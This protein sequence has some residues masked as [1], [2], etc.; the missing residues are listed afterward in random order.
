MAR[1]GTNI[2]TECHQQGCHPLWSDWRKIWGGFCMSR[3]TQQL[4]NTKLH[5]K[6]TT[7]NT[8]THV[9]QGK[10]LS[11]RVRTPAASTSRARSVRFSMQGG[12]A[13]KGSLL[14]FFPTHVFRTGR[15]RPPS[16]LSHPNNPSKNTVSYQQNLRDQKA[17]F[18]PIRIT[19]LSFSP[20]E[21]SILA[22]TR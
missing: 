8:H 22:T 9:S 6:S 20:G 4:C 21:Q 19:S 1:G 16:T 14:C 12:G 17:L 5:K 3:L 2:A 7:K 15:T 11:S 13:A 18:S 10:S